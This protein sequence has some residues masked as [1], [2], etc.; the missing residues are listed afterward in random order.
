ML[1]QFLYALLL[2]EVVIAIGIVSAVAYA[3]LTDENRDKLLPDWLRQQRI[4]KVQ[5]NLLS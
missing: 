5:E 1:I 3:I 2:V 4:K